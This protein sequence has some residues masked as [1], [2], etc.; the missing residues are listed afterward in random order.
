M[1]KRT[2]HV[3]MTMRIRIMM[4]VHDADDMDHDNGLV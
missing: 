2:T 4:S 1:L 3:M